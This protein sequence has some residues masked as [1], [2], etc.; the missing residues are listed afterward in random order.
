ML[1]NRAGFAMPGPARAPQT[2]GVTVVVV[3]VTVNRQAACDDE[4]VPSGASPPTAQA[5]LRWPSSRSPSRRFLRARSRPH[6]SVQRLRYASCQRCPDHLFG[7]RHPTTPPSPLQGSATPAALPC[8]IVGAGHQSH[9]MVPSAPRGGVSRSKRRAGVGGRGPEEGEATA[10]DGPLRRP[11]RI[12]PV[13]AEVRS[14]TVGKLRTGLPP[15][16]GDDTMGSK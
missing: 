6:F 8:R 7:F 12:T 16:S 5:S 13:A 14:P 1:V 3:V 2:V 9:A 15:C 11:P 10:S 4:L